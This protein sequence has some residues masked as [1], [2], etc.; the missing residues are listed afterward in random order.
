MVVQN[1]ISKHGSTRRQFSLLVV[2]LVL[3]VFLCSC[4][5]VESLGV[6]LIKTIG[7][8]VVEVLDIEPPK[9]LADEIVDYIIANDRDGLRSLFSQ[10]ALSEDMEEDI[11]FLFEFLQGNITQIEGVEGGGARGRDGRFTYEY[12]RGLYN[13]T[14]DTG[15]Y[16]LYYIF[17]D[18][19]E[20]KPEDVGLLKMCLVW[21]SDDT[22]E[23][24]AMF[25]A[26]R[27]GI[28]RAENYASR[29]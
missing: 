11:D 8:G 23:V 2:I 10:S 12:R 20:D 15:E 27:R 29:W 9:G 16:Y 5:A 13:I 7:E 28:V 1:G 24:H 3:V 18:T 17:V 19:D 14:T 21:K 26:A 25:D 6:E 22:A 4:G